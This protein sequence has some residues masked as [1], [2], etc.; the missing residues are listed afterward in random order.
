MTALL[1]KAGYDLEAFVSFYGKER[2]LDALLFA[3]DLRA[4]YTIVWL[5]QNAGLLERY[6]RE[7]VG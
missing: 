6:A 4:R 2:L 1:A 5:L 3:K 7:L